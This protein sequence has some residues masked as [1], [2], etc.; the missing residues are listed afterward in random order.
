MMQFLASIF[1]RRR[2][3]NSAGYADGLKDGM[4]KSPA[5]LFAMALMSLQHVDPVDEYVIG[6][7]AGLFFLL[8]CEGWQRGQLISAL[9][10]A[11]EPRSGW[12]ASTILSV[13]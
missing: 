12:S 11:R 13:G 5:E 10:A 4:G 6:Y 1:G 8:H 2:R 9:Q 7:E 3:T